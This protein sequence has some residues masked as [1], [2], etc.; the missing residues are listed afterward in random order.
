MNIKEFIAKIFPKRN[1]EMLAAQEAEK[2]KKSIEQEKE[3]ADDDEKILQASVEEAYNRYDGITKNMTKEQKQKFGEIY[4][5]FLVEKKG[6]PYAAARVVVSAM[7][8]DEEIDNEPVKGIAKQ[9]PDKEIDKLIST[10]DIPLKEKYEIVKE[11]IE[12][13]ELQDAKLEELDEEKENERKEEEEK[14]KKIEKNIIEKLNIIYDNCN[15]RQGDNDVVKEISKVVGMNPNTTEIKK[16]E[17]EIIAKKMAYNYARF[18]TTIIS[19]FTGIIPAI[20][21]NEVDMARMTRI[22]YEEIIKETDKIDGVKIKEFNEEELRDKILS[23]IKSISFDEEEKQA[24]KELNGV[25]KTLSPKERIEQIK[26]M[27]ESV[28]DTDLRK[29]QRETKKLMKNLSRLPEHSRKI[30]I[31]GFEEVLAKRIQIQKGMKSAEKIPQFKTFKFNG[32]KTSKDDEI[33][34]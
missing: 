34:K 27:T 31:K 6:I 9:L 21:M 33:E 10:S 11:G 26:N 5:N 18:G 23:E 13:P 22:Q 16:L 15:L 19:S 1:L 29:T 32:E 14:R 8:E 2:L 17:K 4:V 25:L 24:L 28:K 20:E 12:D 7:L 30:A 3:N